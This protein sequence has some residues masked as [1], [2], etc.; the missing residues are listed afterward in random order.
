M[1]STKIPSIPPGPVTLRSGPEQKPKKK[2]SQSKRPSAVTHVATPGAI[3]KKKQRER[4]EKKLDD[5]KP[6]VPPI[7][8][9]EVADD[10][11]IGLKPHRK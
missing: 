6:V 3:K 11:L 1:G 7:T 5:K 8:F 10:L 2:R 9:Q 4:S